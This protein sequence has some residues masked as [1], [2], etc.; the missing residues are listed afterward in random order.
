MSE[1]TPAPRALRLAGDR[2]DDVR[3]AVQILQQGGIGG[4]PTETVYG[5]AADAFQPRAVARDRR[6]RGRHHRNTHRGA[7]A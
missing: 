7:A 6:A 4:L 1:P 3:R 5:L 2:P